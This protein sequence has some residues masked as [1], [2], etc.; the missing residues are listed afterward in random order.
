MPQVIQIDEALSRAS[1]SIEPEETPEEHRERLRRERGE[2]RFELMK[3]YVLF[4]VFLVALLAVGAI[5]AH[6]AVFNA[7]ASADTK[8]WA[9]TVLSSLLTGALSFVVG[10]ATA[11]RK[12]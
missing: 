12:K 9:Q 3:R 2:A 10:Q 5:S 4:V 11:S 8:R 1:I 7:G 6:E